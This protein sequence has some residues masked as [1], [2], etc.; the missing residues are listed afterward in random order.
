[1]ATRVFANGS[2]PAS[3]PENL[4]HNAKDLHTSHISTQRW[5]KERLR[6]MFTL[7]DVRLSCGSALLKPS[8]AKPVTVSLKW[9]SSKKKAIGGVVPGFSE[10]EGGVARWTAPV[11]MACS[12]TPNSKPG[13]KS[14]FEPRLSEFVLKIEGSKATRKKLLGTLDLA[15]YATYE[16]STTN[17]TIPLEDGAGCLKVE[18]TSSWMKKSALDDDDV[19]SEETDTASNAGEPDNGSD[20][21]DAE[22]GRTARVPEGEELRANDRSLT[23]PPRMGAPLVS[24]SF[25]HRRTPSAGATHV[26]LSQIHT[27]GLGASA[28]SGAAGAISSPAAAAASDVTHSLTRSSSFGLKG[29]SSG[30]HRRTPSRPPSTAADARDNAPDARDGAGSLG[31]SVHRRSPSDGAQHGAQHA[32]TAPTVSAHHAAPPRI[33]PIAAGGG[34]SSSSSSVGLAVSNANLDSWFGTSGG[35]AVVV[36]QK[37][38]K[39]SSSFGSSPTRQ[40]GAA[41]GALLSPPPNGSDAALLSPEA[42]EQSLFRVATEA[43]EEVLHVPMHLPLDSLMDSFSGFD[44]ES[45][46]F[47]RSLCKRLGWLN[48]IANGWQGTVESGVMRRDVH[49]TVK[50]P[51]KAM[52]PDSTRVHLR[53]QLTRRPSGMIILE[54]EVWTLD[55][56]YGETFCLQERWVV[57]P[58]AAASRSISPPS[59][60]PDVDGAVVDGGGGG[61]GN[62]AELSVYSHV[63]FKSK[64]L[65]AAKVS[66]S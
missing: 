24:H 25:G 61:G 58:E 51:P 40:P 16:R 57:T 48:V 32:S 56:P 31:G 15:A 10:T 55:I 11:S 64:G 54:R 3:V 63:F 46:P 53:H 27:G 45:S 65:L 39:R 44:C 38:L 26:S 43:M 14:R 42:A 13:S 36:S 47:G 52:L 17:V 37:D 50:C 2:K 41:P 7:E 8:G 22:G 60:S 30:G 33:E 34:G 59:A 20:D 6:Y 4:R 5:G 28:V 21:S 12:L 23:M 18:L 66:A 1:M 62:A 35:A 29:L 49:C 9:K 19:H